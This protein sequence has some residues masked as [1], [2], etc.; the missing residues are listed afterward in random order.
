MARKRA[1]WVPASVTW[2]EDV[3][4]LFAVEP[5]VVVEVIGGVDPVGGWVRRALEQGAAVVTANKVLLAAHGTGA[6]APRGD[7]RHPDPLRGG[8]R[9]RRAADSRRP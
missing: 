9:R 2:T 7:A 4:E 3:D 8:G 6:A 5:D 1:A